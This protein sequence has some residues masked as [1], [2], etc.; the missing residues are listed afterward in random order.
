MSASALGQLGTGLPG[1]LRDVSRGGLAV[2]LSRFFAPGIL[3]SIELS[4]QT[5]RG[6]RSFPV[7][8][9]HVTPG[10]KNHWIMGCA[11]IYPPSKYELLTLIGQ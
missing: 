5:K 11:F 9:V 2:R 4:K 7:Q 6:A 1:R 3:L 10:G 8:V